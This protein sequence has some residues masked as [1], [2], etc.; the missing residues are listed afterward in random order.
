MHKHYTKCVHKELIHCPECDVVYCAACGKEW[1]RQSI[2][3]SHG[4][5]SFNIKLSIDDRQVI[6]QYISNVLRDI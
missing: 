3:L 6:A 1:K 2:S 5:N 4:L